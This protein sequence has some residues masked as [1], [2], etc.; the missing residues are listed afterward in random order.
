[1]S[2]DTS[3]IQS[4]KVQFTKRNSQSDNS[5]WELHQMISDYCKNLDCKPLTPDDVMKTVS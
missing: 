4:E 3:G 1:M 5:H 2:G